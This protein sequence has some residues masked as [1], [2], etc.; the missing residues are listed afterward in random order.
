MTDLAQRNLAFWRGGFLIALTAF[1]PFVRMVANGQSLYF[2]DLSGQFFPARRFL[3]DG[4]LQGEWRSWN[5]FVHEGVPVALSAFAYPLDLLQLVIPTE[6]GISLSLVLHVPLAAVSFAL[7]ARG[8]GLGPTGGAAGALIYGLGGFSLSTINLY[9]YVQ[10]LAWA[11]L[12]ILA[13]RRAV[14][15]GRPRAIGLAGLTLAVT[16]STTGI[17]I[18]L[19]ACLLAVLMTPPASVARLAR[20]AGSALLGMALAAATILPLL[21]LTRHSERGAGFATSVVLANSVHPLSLVQVL[22]GGFF[23]DLSNLTGAWWGVNFFP[24]GFPYVLSLYLGPLALALAIA[25]TLTSWRCWIGNL[26]SMA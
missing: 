3:L 12:F 10:T 15:T 9:V 21:G 8:L 17:E 5:P 20:S 26:G 4:L 23:G 1:L 16:M 22:V 6:F 24:R 19:Q 7:L 13:F 18:A 14:E 11:P 25:G 2:R